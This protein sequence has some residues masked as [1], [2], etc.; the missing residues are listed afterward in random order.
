MKNAQFGDSI[1]F[2]HCAMTSE[3]TE[4]LL[5]YNMHKTVIILKINVCKQRTGNCIV[6]G[7]TGSENNAKRT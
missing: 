1:L 7:S 4:A 3:K 6:Q 2:Q 5:N